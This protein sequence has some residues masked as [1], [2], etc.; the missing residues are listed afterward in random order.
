MQLYVYTPIVFKLQSEENI[1]LPHSYIKCP[2]ANS[3][4]KK[5]YAASILLRR[6]FLSRLQAKKPT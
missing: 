6:A 2:N 5:N 4:S 1:S 3:N